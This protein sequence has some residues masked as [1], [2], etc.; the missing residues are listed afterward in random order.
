M[1]F[2]AGLKAAWDYKAPK[3]WVWRRITEAD[4]WYCLEVLPPIYF[5]GGFAVS[6]P[7]IHEQG[8]R[9]VYLCVREERSHTNGG[10]SKYFA[11]LSTIR[12]VDPTADDW[13][14]RE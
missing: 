10:S 12:D 5:R 14:A 2:S 1:E 3:P 4:F 11:K 13:R 9:P 6:E 8:D 7:V